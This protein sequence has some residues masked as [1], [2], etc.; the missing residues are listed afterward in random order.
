MKRKSY[1]TQEL[2]FRVAIEA[3]IDTDSPISVQH[4]RIAFLGGVDGSKELQIFR[5]WDKRKPL[6]RIFFKV[7]KNI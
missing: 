4:N 1:K 5:N 2:A 3:K 6:P 7:K